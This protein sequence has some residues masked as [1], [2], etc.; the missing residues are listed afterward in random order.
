MEYNHTLYIGYTILI[1]QFITGIHE[2]LKCSISDK[3]KVLG[4]QLGTEHLYLQ[5]SSKR[6]F[7]VQVELKNIKN[8]NVKYP[9]SICKNVS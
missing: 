4:E 6:G 1:H 7:H 2:I 3:V 8:F 9:P 5:N